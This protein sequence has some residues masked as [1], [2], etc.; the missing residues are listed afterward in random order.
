M[1]EEDEGSKFCE[2]DIDQILQR[3]T[4]TITIE[5]EGRGSTFAKASFVASGNRTD[6]SLDDPNFWDKWAK[7]AEIDVDMVNGRNSLVID[8]PRVRKQTRPF[9]ATKDE[10]AELSEGES[11]GDDK[12]KLRRPHDRLNGYGRTECFR[13]EKNLLVYGWGRWKDILLHGRFKRQLTERDV[14]MICRALLAYCLVHY[15][16]DDKIKSFM[17]DLI[18]PTEDGRT[19]ELQ[20]HLGLSTPVPRGR[21]GKK[22]KSQASSF[23]IHKAEWIRKHNPEHL[24][25][26]D[27]YKKHLKHHC[28]KVL[29]RVRMLY[30][31]KQE[32]IGDQSQKVLDGG[33]SSEIAVWVPELDH[34]ELPALWWDTE[35]DKCLLLGVFKHG[36]EKYNTIR[37][38]PALSFLERVGRPDEKAIAAEQRANDFMDGDVDDPEYKPA[39]ALL[40]DDIEDDVSSPGDL[41]ITDAAGEGAVAMEGDA[42]YW[43]TPSALT[44]RLRRLITASQRY[45]KSRQIQHIHQTQQA[46]LAP[47]CAMLPTLNDNPKMAAK[48]ER[49]QRWT[50]REEADFYR[51]V[52]TFGVVFNPVMG[53]FD[54]TKFRAMARLHKKTDESLQ[55][56]LWAFTAMCRRVCRLPPR[57]GDGDLVDPSLAIQPI[58]EERASRTLYRVEL[59]RK[60][61]EQ[62]LRHPQ[63]YERLAL[64]QPGPTCPRGGSPAPTTGTC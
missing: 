3:R 6:I 59:L 60:V 4:Q 14:E 44:A 24:L 62:V 23:D 16:G 25:Q 17:W 11:D 53:C 33:N 22:M 26:D 50:R 34:S 7:K 5:S 40:K 15:R 1:D 38:D 55:K 51:V 2:E 30:Y 49:Q 29:L 10:L 45:T 13:V 64:C 54:W 48:I 61:R 47:P 43:P 9:S 35:A 52:S 19:K 32:V 36:Y 37:A 58:T 39:P 42:L 56:Y 18:A 8:T 46:F 20:N 41:V 63:L 21:K 12:P 27:G 31:L 57:E 28:N